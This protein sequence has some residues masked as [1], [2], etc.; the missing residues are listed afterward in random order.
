MRMLIEAG[1]EIGVDRG[2]E[3]RKGFLVLDCQTC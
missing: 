2:E 1:R 3:T